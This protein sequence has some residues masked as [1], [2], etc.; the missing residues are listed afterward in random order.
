MTKQRLWQCN[1]DVRIFLP[2]SFV[3]LLD[4]WSES[5]SFPT[6]LLLFSGGDTQ[7]GRTALCVVST[8]VLCCEYSALETNFVCVCVCVCQ[9]LL[10]AWENH[11]FL[12]WSARLSHTRNVMRDDRPTI[13]ITVTTTTTRMGPICIPHNYSE[14]IYGTL[15]LPSPAIRTALLNCME[16]VEKDFRTIC[17]YFIKSTF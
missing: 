16:A 1:E 12:S 5:L 13:I 3:I 7:M 8:N 9:V 14:G 2:S 4:C 17:S 15:A 10:Y 6:P 11:W